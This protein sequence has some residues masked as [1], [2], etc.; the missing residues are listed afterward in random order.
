M[1][2]CDNC[3]EQ[4]GG[5]CREWQEKQVVQAV[6][7]QVVRAKLDEL[8]QSTCP[9]CWAIVQEG[10]EGRA[11][12]VGVQGQRE[13]AACKH[14]L[15]ECPRRPNMGEMEGIRRGIWYSREVDTCRKCGM[16]AYLCE[17]GRHRETCAWPNI[18]VPI[19]YGLRAGA[20]AKA[21][22][23]SDDGTGCGRIGTILGRVG[24]REKESS[25]IGFSKW[26]GRRY[27]DGRVL[28]RVVGNGVAAVIAAILD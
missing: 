8:A 25:S 1:V 28:D 16:M 22:L 5:G 17:R 10:F 3:E 9:Y 11:G 27:I 18:V 20:E 6:Q 15:W 4:Q 26:I 23:A 7:E 14:S 2:G 21:Q 19:L 12:L 24:Y 13:Q